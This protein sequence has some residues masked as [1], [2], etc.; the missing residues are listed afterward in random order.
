MGCVGVS[1]DDDLE[2]PSTCSPTK[3]GVT[4]WIDG[5]EVELDGYWSVCGDFGSTTGTLLVERG[6]QCGAGG[7]TS[8][9]SELVWSLKEECSR[10][11]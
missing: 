10:T 3:V 2:I 4:C 7:F 1:S 6:S 8:D 5:E 11:A 9:C